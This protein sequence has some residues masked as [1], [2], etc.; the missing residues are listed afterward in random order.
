MKALL[1]CISVAQKLLR[2]EFSPENKFQSKYRYNKLFNTE[3][4]REGDHFVCHEDRLKW[5][6]KRKKKK[7]DGNWNVYTEVDGEGEGR[8]R[9]HRRAERY[10][11]DLYWHKTMKMAVLLAISLLVSI[12]FLPPLSA[13]PQ[14]RISGRVFFCLF[15][16]ITF[17]HPIWISLFT[18]IHGSL[19]QGFK[20]VDDIASLEKEGN[21]L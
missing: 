20:M 2:P 5:W 19:D 1:W 6:A 4:L 21:N 3:T 8:R 10:K 9:S 14:E 18:D 11:G 17:H 15:L 16:L 7:K 13:S 12:S